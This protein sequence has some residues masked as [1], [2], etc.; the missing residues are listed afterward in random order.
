MT[1]LTTPTAHA[2]ADQ[3]DVRR[4]VGTRTT[5]TGGAIG[6]ALALASTLVIYLVGSLGAPIRVV[7]GWAPDGAELTAG[8]VIITVVVAVAAGAALLGVAQRHHARAWRAWTVTA[9]LFAIASA[10]PLTRLDV[11]RGSKIAL[12]SM[13]LATGVAAIV[14]HVLARRR[15]LH[16]NGPR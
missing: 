11:D 13:H 7:T 16:I 12:A 6:T 14:G 4:N 15:A 10:V 3:H 9:S 1:T 5:V 2:A 8:E